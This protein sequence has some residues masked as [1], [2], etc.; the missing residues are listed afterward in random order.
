MASVWVYITIEVLNFAIL[1]NCRQFRNCL[2]FTY[3]HRTVQKQNHESIL[4][5]RVILP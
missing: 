1:Q 3:R 4:T 2:A 5:I